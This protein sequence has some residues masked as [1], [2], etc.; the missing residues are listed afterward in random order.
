MIR[1]PPRSTLFPYTTLFRSRG[2]RRPSWRPPQ[3]A[4]G[5]PAAAR[6]RAPGIRGDSHSV[7]RDGG[8]GFALQRR[9]PL[10]QL[11]DDGAVAPPA[12]ARAD[13]GG[14]GFDLRT[15]AAGAELL[16]G[17]QVIRLGEGQADH[18]LAG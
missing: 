6:C 14:C 17:E 12:L 2:P 15:H 18:L 10:R 7:P 9:E 11:G 8:A 5:C 16:S 1:R 4:P 13:E 3:A